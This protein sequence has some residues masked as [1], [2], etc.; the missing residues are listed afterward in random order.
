M[1]YWKKRIK[2]NSSVTN[3][4][5]GCKGHNRPI[6]QI[7]SSEREKERDERERERERERDRER[8]RERGVN[9]SVKR[10]SSISTVQIF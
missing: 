3:F 1:A 7:S 2:Y 8:E 4:L 6:V 5:C 9:R 10:L